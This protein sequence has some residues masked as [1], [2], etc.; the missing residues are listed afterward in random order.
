MADD[1][2]VPAI[3]VAPAAQPKRKLNSLLTDFRNRYGF[4]KVAKAART[5]IEDD[6]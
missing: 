3:P 2:S 4:K 5:E 6:L 1:S